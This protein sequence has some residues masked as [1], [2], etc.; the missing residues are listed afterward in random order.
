MTIAIP[1][2]ISLA[3]LP[4]PLQLLNRTSRLLGG[5]RIW[6]KRDD[7]TGSTLSG[8]KVRKLEFVIAQAIKENAN[9]LVTCGGVQSN[10]C[11]ATAIAAAQQGLK[12][13]LILR[14]EPTGQFDGNLLLDSISGANIS[15]FPKAGFSA[16]LKEY[17]Q[18]VVSK[19]EQRGEKCFCIPTGASDGIGVWGYINC[20]NELQRD[21]EFHGISPKTVICAT[22]SGGT[23]AGLTAGFHLAYSDIQVEAFAVCDNA[24]YFENKAKKDV[25]DCSRKYSV[26]IESEA[27]KIQTHDAYIGAGY[28][29]ANDDIFKTIALVARN[30]GLI[31][32]PVYTGKAFYGLMEEIKKGRYAG[33]SDIVFVHTG[34][35][36]GLFPYR[37]QIENT[38][39][40]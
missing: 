24:E 29:L 26:P 6:V 25:I 5:P 40:H 27:L 13:H 28:G 23:Q 11:R 35:V 21:F 10:H 2:K 34:G 16:R 15:R 19:Y 3:L 17:F 9:V 7:L 8:N 33:Q 36:F 4:T 22:G 14:E 30:D 31:L 18:E 1:D 37:Q 38:L 32:D 12:C 39:N 20:V